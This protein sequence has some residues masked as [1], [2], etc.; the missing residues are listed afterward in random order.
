M[1]TT[2]QTFHKWSHRPW[3]TNHI[4]ILDCHKSFLMINCAQGIS[5]F[6]KWH[7]FWDSESNGYLLYFNHGFGIMNA[8]STYDISQYELFRVAKIYLHY[9]QDMQYQIYV[10]HDSSNISLIS[11]ENI[12]LKFIWYFISFLT[13]NVS[14]FY[15]NS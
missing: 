3:N 9:D 6:D 4:S 14:W 2:A 7:K 1:K 8:H 12:S 11:E 10:C 15:C 5:C 13:F